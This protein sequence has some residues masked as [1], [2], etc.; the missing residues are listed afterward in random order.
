MKLYH[1]LAS[2]L[3]PIDYI[4]IFGL[5]A[6]TVGIATVVIWRKV[7]GKGGCDCGCGGCPSAQ[8][9]GCAGCNSCPSKNENTDGGS[10]EKE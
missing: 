4:L 6:I 8:N 2:G 9:G 5:I 3:N 7:K 10:E 1:L